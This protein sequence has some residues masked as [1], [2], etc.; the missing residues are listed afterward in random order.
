MIQGR[1]GWSGGFLSEF[2]LQLH[3]TVGGEEQG[4]REKGEE[5]VPTGGT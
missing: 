1:G 5:N 3:E 4:C 2:E